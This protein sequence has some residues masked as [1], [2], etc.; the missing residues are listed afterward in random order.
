MIVR[1]RHTLVLGVF[2]FCAAL[3]VLPASAAESSVGD[4]LGALKSPDEAAR[5]QAIDQLGALGP[6]AA[7]AVG[8]LSEL[9]SD[10]SA[11]VRAHAAR[12]LGQIGPAAKP[13]IPALVELL[14]DPDE[15]IR[16]Q[17]IAAGLAIHPGPEVAVPL[18]V[19]LLEDSDPGVR[20]R[21]MSAIADAGSRAVPGLIVALK[22][23]NAA[24]WACLILRNMGPVGKDAVPGLVERLADPRPEV[25]REAALALAAMGEAAAPA[26]PTLVAA[27]DDK[28]MATPAT[29]A[30]GSIGQI[31][32]DAEG[33]IR[34]NVQSA[35][36]VL[37]TT[38]LWA[39]A[40]VHP[41]DKPLRQKATEAIVGRLKDQDPYVGAAAAYALA[42]LPPAPEIT[43][44]ILQKAL[45]GADDATM[46]RALDALASLGAPAVPRLIDALKHERMREQVAFILGRIGPDAAAAA[47]ALGKLAGDPNPHVAEAAAMAL[48][49]IGPGA[50]AATPSLADV[51]RNAQSP[52][53]HAA[54]YALGKIGPNA[55]AAEPALLEAMA[56][57]DQS[58][59]VLGAWALIQVRPK[60]PEVAAKAVPVLTAG[61]SSP[62]PKT[63]QGAAE[64]L[65][66]LGPLAKDAAPALEKA[67]EDADEAVR[68]AA[69]KALASIGGATAQ[70]GPEAGAIQPGGT[71]VT[72]EE[73]VPLQ[74]GTQVL[75]RLPKGTRLKVLK[76]KGDWVGVEAQVAGESKTGWV[77]MSAVKQ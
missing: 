11:Q 34:A 5:L 14:K 13:A 59:S 36:G 61:L 76:I 20:L 74:R 51:V 17:A 52:N 15:S 43:L 22:K 27:L 12:A 69:T 4:L 63:R 40:R 48:A 65:G 18:C 58:L 35:D 60:S 42:S 68:Q 41:D 33:K 6:K 38:S 45:E 29:F 7:E 1:L 70:P 23:D 49:N 9:L 62:L 24:Y 75:A 2:C 16:R 46:L 47:E 10:G 8:P 26:V 72:V 30:L 25:R 31:P 67:A 39:L 77:P 53:R 21:V 55:A 56:S 32:A 73:N 66:T 3:G 54:A 28:Q 44:P 71:V 50:Q 37:S 19:K 57:P 64:S